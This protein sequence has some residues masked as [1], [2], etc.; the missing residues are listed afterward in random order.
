M[1][2]ADRR[3]FATALLVLLALVCPS[4]AFAGAR[5]PAP[6]TLAAGHQ[7]SYSWSVKASRLTGSRPCVNVA[8][9]HR[10]GPFS[11]DRSRFHEC[12]LASPGL[13]R[14]AP[15][16]VVGGTHLGGDGSR[17]TVFG[18]LAAPGARTVR[19]TVPH[20]V[21]AARVSTRLEPVAFP[22]SRA[23]GLRFG[24]IVLP[25]TQCPERLVTEDAR[26]KVLWQGTPSEPDCGYP[27]PVLPE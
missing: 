22:T 9:T 15:P 19:A 21:D 2:A 27:P 10:H 23:L 12:V 3:S 7:G 25:G 6:T 24:L 18:V 11:Y 4:F 13:K 5:S 26:G 20:G 16:L 8:I 17:M 14:T 1:A